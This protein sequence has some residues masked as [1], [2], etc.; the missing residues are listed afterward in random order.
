MKNKIYYTALIVQSF[1]IVLLLSA[2]PKKKG[3]TPPPPPNNTWKNQIDYN[4]K[5]DG[6]QF[7]VSYQRSSRAIDKLTPASYDNLTHI[8]LLAES[9]QY[10]VG[11][12]G[13][14]TASDALKTIMQTAISRK[15]TRKTK[16][17]LCF[18]GGN[19]FFIPIIQDS[20]KLTN[21]LTSFRDLCI[22]YGFDG[23]D[24]DWEHPETTEQ[25]AYA[26]TMAIQMYNLFKDKNL[27][28]SQAIIWY[29][30][31]H[32]KAVLPYIDYIN[33][34]VYDNFDAAYYHSPYSQF[35]GLIDNVLANGIPANKILAGL[36]FYGY[37]AESDWNLKGGMGYAQILT[38]F[39]PPIGDDVV[40][41]PNGQSPMTFNGVVTIWKKCAYALQKNLKGVMI[42][43]SYMDYPNYKSDSSLMFHVNNVFP[44]RN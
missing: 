2:C 21:Y 34:M 11:A 19:S 6:S 28:I 38:T 5:G 20:V 44:V 30:I 15:G 12:D 25:V 9:S 37:Y 41:R 39:K 22:T 27:W 26:K 7:V 1:F 29:N 4:L 36:P 23:G 31:A 24:L 3:D 42:W 8:I 35:P 32:M 17:I 43:E 13:K 14:I 16:M 10:T 18:A 40:S 33:L